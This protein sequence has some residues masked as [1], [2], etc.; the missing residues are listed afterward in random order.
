MKESK[1]HKLFPELLVT[2]ENHK[3]G[4]Y[5]EVLV[6][7]RRT[8]FYSSKTPN[9][10]RAEEIAVSEQELSFVAWKRLKKARTKA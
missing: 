2:D 6:N 7:G 5:L 10:F 9:I 8:Y 1:C 4:N 3:Y